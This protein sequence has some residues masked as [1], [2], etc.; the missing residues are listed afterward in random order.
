[1]FEPTP[2]HAFLVMLQRK[3]LLRTVFTQ[4][5]DGLEGIAGIDRD[6]VVQAHGSF[7]TAH[8][9]GCKKVYDSQLVEAAV[10]DGSVAHCEE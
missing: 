4:N 8:C 1:A 7:D 3:G 10:F 6:K 9:T 5:I 2:S